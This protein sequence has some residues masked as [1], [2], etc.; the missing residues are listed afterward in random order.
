MTK[1]VFGWIGLCLLFL[2]GMAADIPYV[3]NE[4]SSGLA[5]Y[6]SDQLENISASSPELAGVPPIS[7]ASDNEILAFPSNRDAPG[8]KVYQT[9]GEIKMAFDARAWRDTGVIL[10]NQGNYGEALPAFDKAIQLDPFNADNLNSKGIVLHQLGRYR[11]AIKY[12]DQAIDLN[13]SSA[14]IWSNKAEALYALGEY[15]D[16]ADACDVAIG[17]SPRSAYVWYIKG[18]ILKM[19]A[20]NAF[21]RAGMLGLKAESNRYMLV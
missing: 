13:P 3:F 4:S 11:E 5:D 9:V 18:Q 21:A 12:F 16:A 7:G 15:Q 20:E 17:M 6:S 14:A 8:S 1:S 10:Y 19:E 2:P